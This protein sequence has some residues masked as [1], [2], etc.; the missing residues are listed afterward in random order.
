MAAGNDD[1]SLGELFSE[2]AQETSTLVRQEM[3]LAGEEV[4]L[5]TTQA[6]KDIGIGIAGAL[7]LFVSFQVIVAAA[8]IGLIDAGLD[9]WLAALIVAAVLALVGFALLRR[10]VSAIKRRELLPR[11]TIQHLK[12]DQEWVKEQ[13]G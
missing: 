5:R 4:G 3:R 2:L 8:I 7:V 1:R 6:G 13:I 9:W 12:E 10:A 11:R